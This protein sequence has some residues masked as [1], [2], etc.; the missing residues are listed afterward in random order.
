MKKMVP[1][2]I[3]FQ[4]KR[5]VNYSQLRMTEEGE[6]SA[7]RRIDGRR[8]FQKILSVV[9]HTRRLH[10]T[11]VTANVGSDT[12]LF[13]LHFQIVDSIELDPTNFD[14]LKHNVETFK[15]K[16]VR[17]HLGDS[18]TLYNW[19]TDVL[20]IDPPWGG[21]TYKDNDLIDL[22][23]GEKRVDLWLSEI[24]QQ[25]WRPNYIFLKLPTNYNFERLDNLPNKLSSEKFVI[26]KFILIG[27]KINC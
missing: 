25:E 15:L 20:Y 12:I 19:K 21:P 3:I 26:R 16:N 4:E 24:L 6:Y 18:T 27:I 22:Y 2:E 1:M 10:I 7:T 5:G 8:I 13:G 17:T 11:D 23:L 14:V 9:G